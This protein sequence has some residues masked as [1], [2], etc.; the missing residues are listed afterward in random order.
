MGNGN[1]K[2]RKE[3]EAWRKKIIADRREV[4]VVDRGRTK[5]RAVA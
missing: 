2:R 4:Q 5:A 3:P 1:G